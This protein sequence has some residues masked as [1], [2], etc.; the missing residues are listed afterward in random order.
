MNLTEENRKHFESNK[1]LWNE[2]TGVHVKSDF[3]DNKTFLT[4]KNS[5]NKIE[6]DEIGDVKEK[7]VLHLQCHFGQDTLSFV[8]MGAKAM[9]VDFSDEAIR[10]AREMNNK[11]GLDAEFINCNVYDLK[12]HIDKEFDII[13]TSYGVIGWLPDLNE[14]ADL[15]NHF[16]KPGGVF[17]IIEFHPLVWMFDDNFERIEYPYFTTAKPIEIIS[18]KTYTDSTEELSGVTEY[19]WNHALSE[20]M[21][22]LI[23]AG[24][25]IEFI[26]E[27]PY[28]PYNIFPDMYQGSDGY[29]RMKKFG[30]KLPLIFSI[31]AKK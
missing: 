10:N 20:T 29:W 6:L 18:T 31:K 1:K 30:E 19:S 5:L 11:L 22:S 23:D 4:G 8:R 15:I 21:N 16:L 28:S 17:Y 2:R 14:W 25:K 26:H 3:Y 7:S 12:E 24:L 13:F 27:F 9:G